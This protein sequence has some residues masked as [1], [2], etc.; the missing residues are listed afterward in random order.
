MISDVEIFT[1]GHFSFSFI[2]FAIFLAKENAW[3]GI[4]FSLEVFLGI[5]IICPL[6]IG[7]ISSTAKAFEFSAILYEGILP[8]TIILKGED[9][10]LFFPF[11]L[12]PFELF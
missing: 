12:F 11:E 6:V 8:S 3:L 10:W 9:S 2:F 7:L 5:I 1:L 4:S